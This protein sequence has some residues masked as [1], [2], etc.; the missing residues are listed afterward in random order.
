[1]LRTLTRQPA[2]RFFLNNITRSAPKSA[3]RFNS[4]NFRVNTQSHV[5]K[6]HE[7]G[8]QYVKFTNEHEWLAVHKDNSAFIGITT[9]A[10]EALGDTTFVELPEVGVT[11]EVGDSIGS[12]ESVKSASEIYAP[13][14]GEVVAVNEDLESRPQLIN[15]DPMGG[16]WIAQFKLAESADAVAAKEELMDEAAYEASLSEH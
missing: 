7:E 16:G 11:Y 3:V 13:V 2:S 9:Y 14:A 15:E 6:Y 10:S 1:M 12:V 8:P 4:S 5:W